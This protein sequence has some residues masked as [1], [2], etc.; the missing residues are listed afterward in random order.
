M[1]QPL[2]QRVRQL[3]LLQETVKK[4]N[5]ILD[6]EQLLDEIV[7]GVAEA[8]GCNRT[9]VLLKDDA[10]NELEMIALRGFSDVHLKGYRFKIGDEGM[11]GHVG[12]T[13]KMRY[14]PDVRKDPYYVVSESTTLSEVDIPLIVRGKLIGIFNAQ[15]SSVDAFSGEQI[16]L[17]SALADNIAIA[18]ENARLFRH[19]RLEKE[20]AQ[21]E[22][23]EARR[24]Q[25]AL[26]P[27][28][29]PAIPGFAVDGVCLQLSAV[30]GDWYDYLRLGDGVWGIALGDVCGKGMAAA[31]LMSATRS[32]FRT[33]AETSQ[34]P[35]HVLGRLNASLV[36]DLPTGRFVTMAYLVLNAKRAVVKIANAGHP[37][38]L[39]AGRHSSLEELRTEKG[40]P[41]GLMAS[42]YSEIELN[43]QAGDRL[44]IYTDGVAEAANSKDEEY[45]TH[46]LKRA[47]REPRPSARAVLADLQEFARDGT[48]TD[49]ATA[50]VLR[51]E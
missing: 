5:S 17:L 37:Y 18:I 15:S 29:D 21:R 20:K 48:L 34:S 1:H 39:F 46:R 30:G 43:L 40:F 12:A 51:R 2:E 8:F 36:K 50:I 22:Q 44:L 49:D 33:A 28:N 45:G 32:L 13:A 14:A 4:V 42:E 25:R 10:A 47:L 31:L 19:E 11:V 6:L 3:L 26:L 38:P 23:A 27:E 9:A 41:L 35:S 7:G 16:D 24:I